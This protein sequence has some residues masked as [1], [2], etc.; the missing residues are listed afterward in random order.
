V[1]TKLTNQALP[2]AWGSINLI[3]DHFGIESTGEPMAEIWFGTHAGSYTLTESGETLAAVIGTGKLPFLLK[4]LA[5]GKPLSIQAHP[6]ADQARQGFAAENAAGIPIDAAHRNYK[7][8]LAKPELIVAL[9]RTFEALAGFKTP[10]D[11]ANIFASIAAATE[12]DSLAELLRQF[13]AEVLGAGGLEKIFLATL[14]DARLSQGALDEFVLAAAKL[15]DIA[16]LVALL[17]EHNSGDR[18]IVTALMLNHIELQTGEAIFVP[19]GMPHAYLSGLGV[20]VMLASDNVLR[21]GLTPKH[22]DIDELQKVLVFEAN[23]PAPQTGRALAQ[24]L[25]QFELDVD[26]FAFY[27]I[28]PS[29]ANL[30]ADAN[31]PGDSIALCT[32]GE[33]AISTSLGE[34]VV[35]AKGEAAYIS[36]EP[37]TFSVAG[38]GEI[39]MAVS[40]S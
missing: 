9:S 19:A 20:E 32:S 40:L 39:F 2:Y 10:A 33:V 8:A 6:N 13:A 29:A 25:A 5:A 27:R 38:A 15:S 18:G 4:I 35:L 28:S 14:T 1:L 30:L 7:D 36:G 34:R 22:I 17:S 16:P 21:G 31:L 23:Q 12:S 26:E 37:K 3:S 24:G 11:I